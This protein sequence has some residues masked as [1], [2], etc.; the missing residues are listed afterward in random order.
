MSQMSRYCPDCRVDRLFEQYHDATVGC[1]DFPEGE[2][3]EWSCTDCGAALLI[4]LLPRADEPAQMRD[5]RT[6]VA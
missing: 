3:L 2:C 4:G 1:P 6:R 5:I